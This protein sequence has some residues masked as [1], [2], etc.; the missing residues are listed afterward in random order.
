MRITHV[1]CLASL[2][3]IAVVGLAL[4]L[5]AADNQIKTLEAAVD[6]QG[7]LHVPSGYRSAYDF[8]GTWAIAADKGGGSKEI[9]V[10]YATPGTIVAYHK[11][12]HFPD[13]TV[14]VKEVHETSTASMTTGTASH[15]PTLK[16]WFVMVK[17]SKHSH[18]GNRG[19]MA[20]DSRAS[21]QQQMQ[22]MRGNAE[23]DA[24]ETNQHASGSRLQ[25]VGGQYYPRAAD[26]V[27]NAPSSTRSGRESPWTRSWRK[28]RALRARR[29]V[30]EETVESMKTPA[31][32]ISRGEAAELMVILSLEWCWLIPAL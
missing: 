8:L 4:R 13:G 30:P 20:G 11:T 9:H 24:I 26:C 1:A 2:A 23:G 12:S 29:E 21:M 15:A 22:R 25:P 16:G 5:S 27:T 32:A 17:D 28:P 31:N 14:L 19:G 7:H 18:P 3:A 10:V 6:A